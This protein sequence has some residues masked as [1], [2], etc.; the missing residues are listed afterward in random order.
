MFSSRIVILSAILFSSLLCSCRQEI[1]YDHA[2]SVAVA[3]SWEQEWE[4]DYGKG[5]SDA[6]DAAVHGYGYD[7]LR[8][9][10]ASSVTMISYEA[11]GTPTT[12]FLPAGGGV[13]VGSASGDLLLYNDDTECV[14]INDVASLPNVTATTTGRSRSSLAPLHSGERT[15]NPPDVLYGAYIK[16]VPPGQ[17][18]SQQ[19]IAAQLK[20]LVYSY[21]V[22]YTIEHGLEYVSLV[23]GALAGMAESVRLRDGSTPAAAATLLFDCDIVAGGARSVVQSFGVPSFSG[24]HY[25]GISP[26]GAMTDP[27]LKFTLNLEVLTKNGTIQSF[28]FDVTDQLRRQPRGGVI[29]VDGIYVV[30]D[31][32]QVDA[33]FNVDVADWGEFEDVVLPPFEL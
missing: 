12:H 3:I 15:V 13:I 32:G 30:D 7:E 20:P 27:T 19:Q 14:V 10:V 29:S 28:E 11:D 31:A 25:A 17:S 8:P 5:L 1:C 6:W 26:S 16:D 21:V 33:G 24:H 18:H 22:N 4:R 2:G 23:R 9:A